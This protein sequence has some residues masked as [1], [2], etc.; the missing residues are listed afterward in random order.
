MPKLTAHDVRAR[1]IAAATKQVASSQI[2]K[3]IQAAGFS[4]HLQFLIEQIAANAANPIADAVEDEVYTA[5]AND[6]LRRGATVLTV[7]D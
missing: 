5:I 6:R 7:I 4:E 2:A 1:I 3:S